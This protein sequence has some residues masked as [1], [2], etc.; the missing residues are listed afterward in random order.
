[1][2]DTFL[3]DIL[4]KKER[5]LVLKTECKSAIRDG[6]SSNKSENN[7]NNPKTPLCLFFKSS[8]KISTFLNSSKKGLNFGRVTKMNLFSGY[9]FSRHLIIGT[10]ITTSPIDENLRINVLPLIIF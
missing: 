9:F 4:N 3:K 5:T 10:V 1:M 7:L 6:F 8:S 2:T